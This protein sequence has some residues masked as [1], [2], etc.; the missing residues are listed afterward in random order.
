MQ[1]L[2]YTLTKCKSNSPGPDGI[3]YIFIQNFRLKNFFFFAQH[4]QLDM[5]RGTLS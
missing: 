4:L 2:S 1:E 5:E 3:P